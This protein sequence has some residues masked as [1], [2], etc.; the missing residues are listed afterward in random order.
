MPASEYLGQEEFQIAVGPAR[1]S[2][3]IRANSEAGFRRAV[4]E[5][6]TRW[7]GFSEPIVPV[8][9]RG[10]IDAFWRQIVEL[11]NVDQAV[12]VDLDPETASAAALSLGLSFQPISLIDRSGPGQ[13]T[14]H[15]SVTST[16]V[17][18][19]HLSMNAPGFEAIQVNWSYADNS[20]DLWAVTAAGALTPE[21]LQGARDVHDPVGIERYPMEIALAQIRGSTGMDRTAAQFRERW[22]SPAPFPFPAIIWFCNRRSLLECLMYWNLRALRPLAFE[23]IPMMLLPAYA[24]DNWL[25]FANGVHTLLSGRSDQF[26]PDA[27]ICSLRVEH[28]RLRA[29][30]SSWGLIESNEKPRSQM[31]IGGLPPPPR[32]APFTYLVDRDPRQALMWF[33]RYGTATGVL[34]QVFRDKTSVAFESPVHFSGFGRFK[35]NLACDILRPLP[36]RDSVAGLVAPNSRWRDDGIELFLQVLPRYRLDIRI[37]QPRDVVSTL[38]GEVTRG[39]S[40]SDKGRMGEA[41]ASGSEVAALLRPGLFEAVRRLTTPRSSHLVKEIER[42][43]HTEEELDRAK[44]VQEHG[45]RL[46][47]KSQAAGDLQNLKKGLRVEVLELLVETRWA[48][49]GLRIVC[50]VC[51]VTSFLD[52]DRVSPVAICPGCRSSQSYERSADGLAVYYRLNSLIDKASDQG[53][54]PHLLVVAAL[55]QQSSSTCVLPGVDVVFADGSR[56]EVDLFG[57]SDGVVIGG[58]V[59]TSASEFTEEQVRRDIDLSKRL[60]V[61]RHVMACVEPLPSTTVTYAQQV[62]AQHDLRIIILDQEKLRPS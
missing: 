44:F 50:S 40:L 45:G 39:W 18:T 36:R 61:D 41:I 21:A 22:A 15:P 2:Y 11:A 5:A 20:L 38:L 48:E 62:A 17:T 47:R 52:L 23:R 37:P 7:G 6:S 55:H 42:R 8:R 33:R 54:L 59:K 16:Q 35:A 32:T 46:E 58:E 30:G 27:Y 1:V 3:L 25:G 56:S 51:G 9:A 4:Q 10:R 29:I 34:T 26:S 19:T 53:V 43:E 31:M 49:R 57:I 13:Y 60:S 28:E 12:N 14:C 24:A